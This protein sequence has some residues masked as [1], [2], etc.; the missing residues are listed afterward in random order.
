ML[1]LKRAKHKEEAV[2]FYEFKKE[3]NIEIHRASMQK[4]EK[5]E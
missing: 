3:I 1:L 5:K 4:K 2:A